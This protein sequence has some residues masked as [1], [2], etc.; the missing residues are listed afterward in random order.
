LIITAT[1]TTEFKRTNKWQSGEDISISVSGFEGTLNESISQ[2]LF[3][4]TIQAIFDSPAPDRG[5]NIN[6]IWV[7]VN[8]IG[9]TFKDA[10]NNTDLCGIDDDTLNISNAPDP[11]HLGTEIEVTTPYDGQTKSLQDSINDGTLVKVDGNWSDWGACSGVSQERTCTNPLPFCGGTDC[12][13]PSTQTCDTSPENIGPNL[14]TFSTGEPSF[15]RYGCINV[16]VDCR[17]GE[18]CTINWNKIGYAYNSGQDINV[19][20]YGSTTLSNGETKKSPTH[21]W[22]S[23][24]RVFYYDCTVLWDTTDN[25]VKVHGYSSCSD[26]GYFYTYGLNTQSPINTVIWDTL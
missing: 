14:R 1:L 23:G 8:G 9:M 7:S 26:C 3:R 11:S 19:G 25:K 16:D 21:S 10:L 2:D 17:N 22:T 5:H 15:F 6:Q 13:G 20:N 12:V 4:T 24:S 18:P